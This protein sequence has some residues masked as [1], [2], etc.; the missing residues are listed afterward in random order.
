M[1]PANWHAIGYIPG[2]KVVSI[3]QP[4]ELSATQK[5]VKAM[6]KKDINA[7]KATSRQFLRNNPLYFSD[8]GLIA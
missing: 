1:P 2:M 8:L 6:L 5:F 7:F 3:Q 4:R